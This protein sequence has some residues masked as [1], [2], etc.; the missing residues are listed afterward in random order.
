MLLINQKV[1][2][3]IY[4]FIVGGSQGAAVF[5]R[6]LPLA[7]SLLSADLRDRL[8]ITQQCRGDM[9]EET[10]QAYERAGL[11][12]TVERFFYNIEEQFAKSHLI[13]ARAGAS[14]VSEIGTIG[15]PALFVPFLFAKD[16]H[17]TANAQEIV[18]HKA[19][20]ILNEK[21]FIAPAVSAL[22]ADI[23][24]VPAEL[25]KRAERIKKLFSP[26]AVQT[27]ADVLENLIPINK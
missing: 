21:E 25:E 10:R 8:Y 5:S 16:D 24:T 9:L 15:R 11:K 13:I 3:P 1:T 2:D 14:T 19:A 6:V 22:L 7:L 20:W 27:L 12:A 26:T 4:L 17:Q 18:N 23:L